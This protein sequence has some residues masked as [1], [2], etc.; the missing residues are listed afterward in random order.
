MTD[1]LPA[2][3]APSA[4]KP[5]HIEPGKW[6]KVILDG[7]ALRIDRPR[8]APAWVP[9][10]RIS[11]I[12]LSTR[13]D[14]TLDAI[15][16]CA[17]RGIVLLLHDER[18]IPA[19]RIIGRA[20]RFTQLRQRLLD[21]TEEPDWRK[22]Y[23]D[24]RYAMNRR[25]TAIVGR[26]LQAP[27]ALHSHPHNMARWLQEQI[28]QMAGEENERLTRHLF[29]QQALIWMQSRL[30]QLGLDAENELWLA[31]APDLSQEL[32]DLLAFRL[33]TIRM[34]WLRG[35]YRA[36][37]RRDMEPAPI[38]RRAVL[39]KTEQIRPRMEKLGQDIVNRLHRWLVERA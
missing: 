29:R 6:A 27:L 33:E 28:R 1:H 14:I 13:V 10:R 24:W 8:Q 20:G 12:T 30:L 25:I 7:P 2:R 34:G 15:L 5:L 36:L 11:R 19:A 16:A 9:L 37:Q 38:S 26:R 23:G 39:T 31:G 22:N 4:A 32:A 18:E 3:N 17:E 21:L 35:R